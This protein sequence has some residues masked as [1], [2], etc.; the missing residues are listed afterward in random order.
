MKIDASQRIEQVGLPG[1]E[2]TPANTII[3]KRQDSWA[4]SR[5]GLGRDKRQENNAFRRNT[6]PDSAKRR[7]RGTGRTLYYYSLANLT[8]PQIAKFIA[9]L[10]EQE[11]HYEAL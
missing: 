6:V 5:F 7:A 3:L 9:F 11:I 8:T 4:A 2:V 1:V 10:H